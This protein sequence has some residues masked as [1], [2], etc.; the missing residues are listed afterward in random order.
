M[1]PAPSCLLQCLASDASTS[2]HNGCSKR[3]VLPPKRAG[4]GHWPGPLQPPASWPPAVPPCYHGRQL[5]V[6]RAVGKQVGG[7][8][9][10]QESWQVSGRRLCLIPRTQFPLCGC[11]CRIK[12]M[13]VAFTHLKDYF[14]TLQSVLFKYLNITILCQSSTPFKLV[15]KQE[16]DSFRFD[17]HGKGKVKMSV[18]K[19]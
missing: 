7:Q 15:T 17:F 14:L 2:F 9:G 1:L 11:Y 3:K 16:R 12:Y 5:L 6:W 10:F 19:E 18:L 8:S 13:F 4:G